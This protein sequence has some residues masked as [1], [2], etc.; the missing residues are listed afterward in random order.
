MFKKTVGL[1]LGLCMALAGTAALAQDF[2]TKTV[3]IIVAGPPAGGTDFM[4]R[5]IAEKLAERWKQPVVVENK[6]GASGMIGTKFVMNAEPD[7]YTFMLGHVATHAIVPA[8]YQ[9]RPYDPVGDFTPIALVATAPEILIVAANSPFKTVQDIIDAAREKPESITYGSPGVGL[10]QHLAGFQLG[11]NTET[12]MR[13]IPYRGTAP[14]LNDLIGGQISMMFATPPAVMGFVKDGRVR[15]LA[16]TSEQRSQILPGVPTFEEL[17]IN[18]LV[19]LGWFGMFGPAGI[20]APVLATLEKS[21]GAVLA[22]PVVRKKI[23]EMYADPASATQRE[24]ADYHRAEVAKWTEI[25][26][27]S[28]IKADQ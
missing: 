19:Q 8:I 26:Q 28:G 17:K 7:G 10:P 20:P 23:E 6:A 21:I 12:R 24:F 22:D 4:A 14:A 18:G 15:A 1:L 13:H 5:L 16:V 25:V 3:R 11:K 27:T 2:P 9:P